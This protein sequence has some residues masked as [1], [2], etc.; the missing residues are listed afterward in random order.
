MLSSRSTT[1]PAGPQRSPVAAALERQARNH[2]L[3]GWLRITY[4]AQAH[5]NH[6]GHTRAYPGDL[7]RLLDTNPREVSRA[8][9]LARDRGLL[10]PCSNASCIVLPGHA[11]APC[12]ANHR[13]GT[14]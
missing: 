6:H 10:D 12:D 13:E 14:Q 1:A 4:W 3:P 8:I 9:R 5:A 7:R 11:L 2:R